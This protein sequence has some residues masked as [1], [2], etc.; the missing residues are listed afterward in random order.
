ME[1]KPTDTKKVKNTINPDY[2]H[3]KI[4]SFKPV[5][6]LVRMTRALI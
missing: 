3:E 4:F 2:K 1:K 6:K 5:T